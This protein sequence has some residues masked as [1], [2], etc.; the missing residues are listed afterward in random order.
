MDVSVSRWRRRAKENS[1]LTLAVQT[2]CMMQM[3]IEHV[4]PF[5]VFLVEK[6]F[7][8]SGKIECPESQGRTGL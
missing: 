8:E 2:E 3:V 7:D 6:K 5:S 1:A 4:L